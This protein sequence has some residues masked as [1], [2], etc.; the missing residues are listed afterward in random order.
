MNP[1]GEMLALDDIR[2]NLDVSN[3]AQLLDQ[4]AAL[5]ATAAGMLSDRIFRDK[6]KTST[7]PRTVRELL[8]AWP[9]APATAG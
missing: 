8:A 7:D 5:L 1:V 3:K 2:L 6:L 9:E 4:V